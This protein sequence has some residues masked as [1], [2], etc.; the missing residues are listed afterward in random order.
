MT[1]KKVQVWLSKGEIEALIDYHDHNDA[2]AEAMGYVEASQHHE[3]RSREL[4]A[5]RDHSFGDNER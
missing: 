5:L 2:G 1:N 3:K 4:V